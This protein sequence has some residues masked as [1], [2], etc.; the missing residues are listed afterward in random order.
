[1]DIHGDVTHTHT[2]L[3]PTRRW[4]LSRHMVVMAVSGVTLQSHKFQHTMGLKFDMSQ[5]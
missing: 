2:H 3:A 5:V 4:L 1:M